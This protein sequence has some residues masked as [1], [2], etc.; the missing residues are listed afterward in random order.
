MD[1]IINNNKVIR[2][3]N[4]NDESNNL[5]EEEDDDLE[6]STIFNNWTNGN[7]HI[8]KFIQEVQ[9][10]AKSVYESLE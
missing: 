8:D 1:D 6:I 9:L 5:N 3:N 10:N 4:L 7:I 2:E